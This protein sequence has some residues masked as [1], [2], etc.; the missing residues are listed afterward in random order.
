ML[1]AFAITFRETLEAVLI[2]GIILS[3]LRKIGRKELSKSVWTGTILA[4]AGSLI[5][6]LFFSFSLVAL[7]G[8][9][10]R[11]SKVL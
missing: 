2:V 7:K 11:F 9:R 6:A 8:E 1:A 5:L 10:S 3:L 4:T